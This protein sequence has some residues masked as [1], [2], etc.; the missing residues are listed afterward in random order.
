MQVAY[1]RIGDHETVRSIAVVLCATLLVACLPAAPVPS[2]RPTDAVATLTPTPSPT[3]AA[4][5]TPDLSRRIGTA[6]VPTL[7][8]R[9]EFAS[10]QI[11]LD[12]PTQVGQPAEGRVWRAEPLTVDSSY[13]A[14]AATALG[15]SGAGVV[16]AAPGGNPAWRLWWSDE[17]VLA[18]NTAS[19]EIL[20]FAGAR[21]DGPRPPGPAQPDPA[22]ALESLARVLGSSAGFA[23]TPGY[24]KAFRGAESTASLTDIVGGTWTAPGSRDAAIIFPRYLDPVR[25]EVTIYDT[26][27]VGLFTS[28][29]RPVGIV[30]RPIGR[31]V[32][33]EIY[34]VTT[35]RD[36]VKELG[37][38]PQKFLRFVSAPLDAPLT[39]SVNVAEIVLGH[40]WAQSAPSDLRRA[41]RTLVPVWVFPAAGRS[42]SGTLV[43]ALFTVDA[44]IPEMRAPPTSSALNVD[45]DSL[46]RQQLAQLGG[47]QP[48]LRD[49]KQV[50]Q[51]FM[52]PFCG[53]VELTVVD[54]D[55]YSGKATC[56]GVATTFNVSRAFPGLADSIWY[57]SDLRK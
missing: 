51:D 2:A 11:T 6:L 30:H 57:V 17:S 26:D 43:T 20:F 33:G 45:A 25:T 31:L 34:P 40:A 13:I 22:G 39:L 37:A 27:E 46:L 16:G 29:L 44:V 21:D 42:A 47:H 4:T 41:G 8:P 49:P 36:A 1:R 19:G 53:I 32:G 50:A 18:V 5:A 7:L 24:I 52:G 14:H 55:R 35:L 15:A 9:S 38:A 54:A 48:A 10:V 28:R 12:L 23:P 3:L 56:N